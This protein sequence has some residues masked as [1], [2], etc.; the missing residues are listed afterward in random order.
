MYL[1]FYDKNKMDE[2]IVYRI[3]IYYKIL[4]FVDK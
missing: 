4:N 2:K 3:S 1:P